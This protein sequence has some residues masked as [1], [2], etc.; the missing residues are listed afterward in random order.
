MITLKDIR[1]NGG[2][3]SVKASVNTHVLFD[4]WLFEA[5]QSDDFSV[6]GRRFYDFNVHL[7]DY[8][9]NL[10]RPY[11]WMA[12][13][14]KEFI[15]SL[16]LEKPIEEVVGLLH[17]L[18]DGREVMYIIDGKQRLLTIHK[19]LHNEFPIT[20]NGADVYWKDFDRELQMFFRS[21][22]NS[23]IATV[24]YSDEAEPMGDRD[25]IL[26][27]NYYNFSGTAQTEEHKKMLYGLL[28]TG[29]NCNETGR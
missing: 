28:A 16:L 26:L 14:Q 1:K 4:H 25:K 2:I 15:N 24:Y 13:Q 21:R 22:V 9:K 3:G 20:V 10:Q 19:F 18:G 27:F 7:D 5:M 12:W 11:V 23:I 29:G 6:R 17:T 8:G